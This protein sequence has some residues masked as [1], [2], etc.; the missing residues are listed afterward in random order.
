VANNLPTVT[1]PIPRD[2]QQFVQRV[3]EALDGNGANAVVTTRQLIA[4]GLVT[5]SSNGTLSTVGGTIQP[6][7]P[8]AGL[9]TSGALANI[10]VSW[11]GPT[12]KG[13]AYTEVWAHTADII[14]D[15][16][17]VGMTAGNNFAHNIGSAATRYYWVKNVNQNGVASAFNATNGTQGTTGT[18]P[19]YVLS[20]LAGE[21]TSS[22]LHSDLGA[23]IG[24]IDGDSTVTGSVAER[25]ANEALARANAISAETT[26][27]GLAISAE[28]TARG[29]AITAEAT[30]RQS[31]INTLAA[32]VADI[33]G[34]QAYDAAEAYVVG[35]LVIDNSRLYRALLDGTG[36]APTDTTY[37]ELVGNYS[38]IG[39]VVVA[40]AGAVSTLNTAVSNIEG[41]NT[42][43]AT[44]ITSLNTA[45]TNTNTNVGTNASAI[46]GLDTRV[47]T[48]EGTITSHATNITSLN[49]TA[50]TQTTGISTNASALTSLTT[51]VSTAE[52]DIS[53]QS[54]QIT[55]LQAS[56]SDITGVADYDAATTYATGDFVKHNNKLYE[57]KQ[58]S[59]GNIPTN[60]TYW[61][62][63]GDFTSITGLVSAN[64]AAVTSLDTRVTAAEGTI[65][66]QSTDITSLNTSLSGQA[67]TVAANSTAVTDLTTRVTS[68]EGTI[69]T[70]STDITTLQTNTT[71]NTTAQTANTTAISGLDTR[72]TTA[73][74]NIT[75]HATDITNLSVDLTTAQT[76]ITANATALSTLTTTVTDNGT[77]ITSNAT[78]ITDLE[79]TVNDDNT[80][81]S[82]L[83]TALGALTTTVTDNG[84]DITTN[85]TSITNLEST[86]NDDT[87]G[88]SAVSTALGT[89]TTTVGTQGTAI[90]S[91]ATS[92][93][94]L[95][96][97]VGTN[98]T[99]ISTASTS[100]NGIEAK[101]TVKIDAAGHI[102]GYGLISTAN[103][104]TP[105]S[106]FGVRADNFWVSPP[107]NARA[108]APTSGRYKGYV[109]YDTTNEV[110]KYWTGTSWAT[111]PQ[112]V[113]FTIRTSPG[114]INGVD[115][116]AGVYID[117]AMIADATISNA[118]IGSL[119]ADKITAS[120]MNTVDFYGNTIAGSTIYLGGTINYSQ[121]DGVNTGIASVSNPNVTMDTNGASFAVGAFKIT[122]GG[123]DTAPFE[124]VNNTVRIKTATIGNGTITNAKIAN[125]IQSTDYNAGSAGWKIDKTGDVE[126]ND[127]TFRGTLDVGG[128]SG[129][130]LT[131]SS[132]KIEVYDGSTLRVKIG[133]LS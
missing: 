131:I 106:S 49:A 98:T 86:V 77:D 46:T 79:S 114:T 119:T 31:E 54:G 104:A 75:S 64:T 21:I 36:N 99:S 7:R 13:H 94:T 103:D 12:Y 9:N 2:L 25:I 89:L 100:I 53:S 112:T 93:T 59:T 60:T 101:N 122:N 10:I 81:L 26:A 50:A 73:E 19:A 130:R 85:A 68:A 90:T 108:T 107:S 52:T 62:E 41:V 121:T 82:A 14:A 66:T 43:Q 33:T 20:V 78:A 72:V 128:S 124:V 69:T 95:S 92:L 123:S 117:T 27:R 23:R 55:S 132:N 63:L 29:L 88:L 35:D 8:P 110:T 22:E 34:A 48:A 1:S 126:L 96:T 125:T 102:S 37:W 15:A 105:T 133:D 11:D 65:T 118:Q 6:P 17:L 127:A 61:E 47:T 3:R 111:S 115:V 129:S 116:P 84:T 91:N 113:P 38:S 58:A 18:D 39:E 74:T 80:G 70:Q 44:S 51:R 45:V 83:S 76:D 40:N 32:S 30:A 4:A 24:L 28:S 87:N 67:T 120:L 57:A 5:G 56:I 109:W 42:T 97:T 16:Q 71:N